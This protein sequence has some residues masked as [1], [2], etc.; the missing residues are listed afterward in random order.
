MD[1][2]P[3]R[4]A[5]AQGLAAALMLRR[6]HN[7]T[8]T[9]AALVKEVALSPLGSGDRVRLVATAKHAHARA[10][11]AAK[12]LPED[13]RDVSPGELRAVGAAY[14]GYLDQAVFEG[15]RRENVDND[16]VM[17]G[18]ATWAGA[19]VSQ[20]AIRGGLLLFLCVL[21]DCLGKHR[22]RGL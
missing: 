12:A 16:S 11:E 14:A 22:R 6:T 9:A 8:A 4:G 2:D 5:I 20:L 3:G 1:V 18:R 19:Q 7:L 13:E 10:L 17:L 21:I 15:M